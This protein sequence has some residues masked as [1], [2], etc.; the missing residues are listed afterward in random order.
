VLG[1][2]VP[3]QSGSG[4]KVR[5]GSISKQ[6]DRYL[7]RLLVLGA[8]T[9][10]R[11]A[12]HGQASVTVGLINALLARRPPPSSKGPSPTSWPGWPGLSFRIAGDTVLQLRR[13]L[14]TRLL[15]D[16]VFVSLLRW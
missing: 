7:R 8:S 13:L 15:P 1:S 16:E 9:L 4:G 14:E 3:R 6:G 2:A 10:L 5:L 11:H 12:R